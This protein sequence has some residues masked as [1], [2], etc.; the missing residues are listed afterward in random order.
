VITMMTRKHR[1]EP[2]GRPNTSLIASLNLFY[3]LA[4]QYNCFTQ[5]VHDVSEGGPNA[6]STMVPSYL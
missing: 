6:I 5:I 3:F 1:Q 4:A 2:I